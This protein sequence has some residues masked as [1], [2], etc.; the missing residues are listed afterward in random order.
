LVA[1]PYPADAECAWVLWGRVEDRP[2]YGIKGWF[3]RGMFD[4]RTACI[5]PY[6]TYLR[7]MQR[8]G[9]E[10]IGGQDHATGVGA[11]IVALP[12]MT[13][14]RQYREY[15]VCRPDS[16]PPTVGGR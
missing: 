9:W 16:V 2:N 11:V 6:D 15:A 1:V 5:A 4:T 12:A 14:L 10:V 3:A 7:D 13:S 8:L